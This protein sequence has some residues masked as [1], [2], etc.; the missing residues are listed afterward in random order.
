MYNLPYFKEKD[1][2]VVKQ[3]MSANPFA[4]LTGCDHH[5]QPVATQVPLLLEER[6]E[7]LF[8]LGHVQ[9][10]TDHCLAFEQ[11]PRAL[12]V[13]TGPH[14]YVSASLYKNKQTASTWNYI[15]V[16]ASG[17][18]TFLDDTALLDILTRTTALFENDKHSPALVEKM[19]EEYINRMMKAIVAFELEITHLDNVF[20]LSQNR[21]QETYQI[22]TAALQTQGG[23]AAAIAGEMRQREMDLFDK[24][25][26]VMGE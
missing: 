13:F 12:A 20:K 4:L 21:D 10:K 8:L 17:V 19:P 18:L 3:F 6:A 25:N 5:Q 15:S 2:A 23:P 14:S 11:N 16:H 7:K 24:N 22:I 1:I 26:R 9:R